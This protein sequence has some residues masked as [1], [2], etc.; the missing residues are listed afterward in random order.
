MD[1]W[2]HVGFMGYVMR[3]AGIVV[4]SGRSQLIFC[5]E[6]REREREFCV[7]SVDN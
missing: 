3:L 1:Q 6:K 7:A 5:R 4:I 2:L